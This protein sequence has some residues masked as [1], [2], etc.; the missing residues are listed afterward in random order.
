MKNFKYLSPGNLKEANNWLG[1]DRKQVLPIAG[2]TDLLGLMKDS[3][4]VPEKLVNLK[5]IPDLNR[6]TY[7]AGEGLEL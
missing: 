6:V 1:N 4:E 2:G 7:R 5:S 3:I